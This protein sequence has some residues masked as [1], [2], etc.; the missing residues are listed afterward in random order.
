MYRYT[1]IE[2]ISK[3]LGSDPDII[4]E[5]FAKKPVVDILTGRN[6]KWKDWLD[7]S[8]AIDSEQYLN[9]IRIIT[10]KW[11]SGQD[12]YASDN[13]IRWD[14][15][16][17]EMMQF[18][19]KQLAR[20]QIYIG[21]AYDEDGPTLRALLEWFINETASPVRWGTVLNKYDPKRYQVDAE[22]N[23]AY[24]RLG[25][26]YSDINRF[27]YLE[28]SDIKS[29]VE[30]QRSP[31]IPGESQDYEKIFELQVGKVFYEAYYIL[32]PEGFQKLGRGTSWCTSFDTRKDQWDIVYP[33]HHK[34]AGMKRPITVQP[35]GM[36]PSDH[37][38]EY[39][40]DPHWIIVMTN[41]EGTKEPWFQFGGESF[42]YQN[43]EIPQ[44][45]GI[46]EDYFL[47][48]LAEH[49]KSLSEQEYCTKD[50]IRCI[51]NARK[52]FAKQYLMDGYNDTPRGRALL[53]KYLTNRPPLITP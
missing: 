8:H 47:G 7:W 28:L 46:N 15:T 49:A 36:Y 25:S 37:I 50:L 45:L 38:S 32:E 19:A 17:G 34:K 18:I 24:A 39:W 13:L 41:E 2:H 10:G 16:G 1:L 4:C 23:G 3:S 40:K 53:K 12:E 22:N 35:S 51:H 31:Y 21:I 48:K 27:T 26:A 33:K 29:K 20:G 5:A 43:N 30:L 9:H 11:V 52:D 42:N 14:P 6:S 44:R